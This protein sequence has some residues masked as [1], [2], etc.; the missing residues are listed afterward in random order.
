M[1]RFKPG[2]VLYHGSVERDSAKSPWRV[3]TE[4]ERDKAISQ[5]EWTE[6]KF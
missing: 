3:A 1:F 5:P 6:L 2:F 4:A